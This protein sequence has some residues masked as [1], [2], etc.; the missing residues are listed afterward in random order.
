MNSTDADSKAALRREALARRKGLP[1]EIRSRLTDRLSQEGLRLARLWAPSVASAFHPIREEPDTLTLLGAL[2]DEGFATALPAV[3]RRG[4]HLIFR[5]WRPGDEL[6]PERFGTVRATG[7]ETTPDFLLVP[8]LAFDP[9]GHRL[10]YGAGYYDRTIEVLPDAFTLGCAY[11]IQEVPEVPAG[12]HD[13]P[14][15]AVATEQGVI[16]IHKDN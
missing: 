1:P 12:P 9:R 11:A 14:L 13:R 16:F 15:G 10:G 6:I 5:L 2:A 4:S 8:L 3:V 7:P